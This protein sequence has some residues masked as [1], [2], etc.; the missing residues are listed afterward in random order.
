MLLPGLSCKKLSRGKGVSHAHCM[1]GFDC[2]LST[3][4]YKY[5]ITHSALLFFNNNFAMV[6][7][8][9]QPMS[10]SGTSNVKIMTCV[11]I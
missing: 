5:L 8:T 11:N 4:Q 7:G 3:S 9:K 10:C 6:V 1:S 2:P